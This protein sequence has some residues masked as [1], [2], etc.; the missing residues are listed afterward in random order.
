MKRKNI[1]QNENVNH[2]NISILFYVSDKI[3]LYQTKAKSM[4][5]FSNEMLD[6]FNSY[7]KQLMKSNSE[8][9][10]LSY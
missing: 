3:G 2:G 9:Y 7:L 5:S 8:V 6:E 10:F 4:S 1:N